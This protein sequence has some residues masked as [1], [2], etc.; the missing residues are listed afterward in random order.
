MIEETKIIIDDAEV[1]E[2]LNTYFSQA[3]SS[4]DIT[5]PTYF[6]SDDVVL[7]DPIDLIMHKFSNHTIIRI[8][9]A[10]HESSSF[11]FAP[12]KWKCVMKL[13]A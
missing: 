3:L 5:E 1:A 7:N 10:M 2:T 4:L 6:I 13:T 9:K 11:A 8:I 12:V